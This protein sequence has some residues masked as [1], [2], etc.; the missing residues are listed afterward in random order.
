MGI[1]DRWKR[2]SN[3]FAARA[4]EDTALQDIDIPA[5]AR[6]VILQH[7]FEV[8]GNLDY[9]NEHWGSLHQEM[10]LALERSFLSN[11]LR[12]PP[13]MWN[14]DMNAFLNRASSSE[15]ATLVEVFLLNPL[16]NSID[17]WRT[18][19]ELVDVFNDVMRR[20]TVPLR[21]T[22]AT[23]ENRMVHDTVFGMPNVSIVEPARFYLSTDDLID[24]VAI[25]PTMK[26]LSQSVYREAD[27]ELRSALVHHKNG[28]FRDCLTCCF[29][30]LES[31]IK[32][33][34][35]RL[36]S[37]PK[38]GN[39]RQRQKIISLLQVHPSLQKPLDTVA[40][41]RNDLSSAHG[42][43]GEQRAPSGPVTEYVITLTAASIRF[44]I[45]SSESM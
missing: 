1:L 14:E 23:R 8:F 2:L 29:S 31:V 33:C 40:D 12:N 15:F 28:N 25:V 26:V 16:L 11:W 24:E 30:A 41:V 27:R 6:S 34:S 42:A 18:A 43:G 22:E 44:L 32:I 10:C 19:V 13:D 4:Q 3:S 9:S 20:N 45:E 36:D 39:A 5:P 38:S 35:S 7:M 37:L 17:N 21:L